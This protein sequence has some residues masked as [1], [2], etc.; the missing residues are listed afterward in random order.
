MQ[1]SKAK[2]ILIIFFAVINIAL[3]SYIAADRIKGGN[4][5]NAVGEST[6]MLL[7]ENN[8]MISP[9][10]IAGA[11]KEKDEK[12][13]YAE[14]VIR[15]Y[16][17]FAK[18]VIGD[19]ALPSGEN[20]YSSE[21]G[22]LVFS[23][24]CFSARAHKGKVLYTFDPS[25]S[26]KDAATG[27]LDMLGFHTK[28]DTGGIIDISPNG[29]SIVRIKKYIAKKEIYDAG[30]S[31]EISKEGVVSV[32]GSWYNEQRRGAVLGIRS[33]GGALIDYMNMKKSPLKMTI[34][35][36]SLGYAVLDND[37]FHES[38]ILTPVWKITDSSGNYDLLDARDN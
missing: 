12:S 28:K 10:I 33:I 4:I 36:I 31:V 34:T 5:N 23:G 22:K 14:N 6:L 15:D 25:L 17:G 19:D 27:Y 26:P 9:D 8:I 30:V 38:A 3:S 20:E 35:D 24:D 1:W 16:S 29:N 7:E 32:E 11:M 18:S 37:N 13:V 21:T 2:T